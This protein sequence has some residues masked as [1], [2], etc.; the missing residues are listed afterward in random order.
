M[1]D[2]IY[3][4]KV[5]IF[6]KQ[7]KYAMLPTVYK[8]LGLKAKQYKVA[9]FFTWCLFLPTHKREAGRNFKS[10]YAQDVQQQDKTYTMKGIVWA[11]VL[12]VVHPWVDVLCTTET[13]AY[14]N[15]RQRWYPGWNNIWSPS[16]SLSQK[17]LCAA[18]VSIVSQIYSRE[19]QF[20]SHVQ[21][22]ETFPGGTSGEE[23]ACQRRRCKRCGFDPW[24]GKIHWRR[25]WKPTP[26]FLPPGESYG[27][28]SLVIYSPQS[29][30]EPDTT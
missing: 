24:V 4:L 30:K 20:L 15:K 28:R 11:S 27:Q 23:T 1:R 8:C 18:L 10:Q 26:Q 22:L 7:I 19:C 3:L 14:F 6:E 9:Q 13:P 25:A 29:H 17:C 2:I 21:R 5:P 12:S 16:H